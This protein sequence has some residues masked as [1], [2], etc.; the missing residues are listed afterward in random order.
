MGGPSQ[1]GFTP[2][3]TKLDPTLRPYVD[4]ALSEAERLRQAGGPAY[5][6]GET[7]VKP[8]TTTQVALQLAQNRAAAGSPL[9]GD[10][11]GTISGLMGAQSPYEAGYAGMAGKTSR[12]GSVFDQIGQAQS[13]YQH[14]MPLSAR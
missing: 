8:S 12:Y 11:Q 10:A 5:Y 6:G 3:E 13:P 1:Q 7:Y 9:L 14:R 4:T 2:T